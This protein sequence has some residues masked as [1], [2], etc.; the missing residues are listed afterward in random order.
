M[1]KKS[2]VQILLL[3]IVCTSFVYSSSNPHNST[4]KIPV[5]NQAGVKLTPQLEIFAGLGYYNPSLKAW[6]NAIKNFDTQITTVGGL[7]LQSFKYVKD[8]TLVDLEDSFVDLGG[9][10]LQSPQL[11]SLKGNSI[12]HFG[13]KYYFNRNLNLSLSFAHYKADASTNY[14][15]EGQGIEDSWP[16]YGYH[17]TDYLTISQEIETYPTLIT[18]FYMLP[19]SPMKETVEFYVGGGI[20]YYFST[21]KTELFKDYTLEHSKAGAPWDSLII[22]PNPVNPQILSNVRAKANPLGYHVSAGINIGLGVF[23][24]NM[25]LGYNFVTAKMKEKDWT[26]YSRKFTPT[27]HFEGKQSPGYETLYIEDRK[28]SFEIPET[29]FDNFKIDKLDFSGIIIKGGVGFCF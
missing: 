29:A 28:Y 23:K 6:N 22:S 12:Y 19:F 4:W 16:N 1:I 15:A 13:I 10:S 24:I 5:P 2:L 25:E 7:A 20:G 8:E 11:N 3:T 27:K 26:F 14:F 17:I 9:Y 18:L 21:V